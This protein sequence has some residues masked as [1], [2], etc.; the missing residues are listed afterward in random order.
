MLR[1]WGLRA[2][3]RAVIPLRSVPA[4]HVKSTPVLGGL[5]KEYNAA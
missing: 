3:D 1:G 4:A 2:P 5:V